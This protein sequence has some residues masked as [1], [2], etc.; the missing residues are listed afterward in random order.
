MNKFKTV[1]VV[2]FTIYSIGISAQCKV[3]NN[4]FQAGEE[5]KYDLYFKY[6]LIDKKAGTSSLTT[7]SEKYNNVDAYKMTFLVKST[8]FAKSLFSL[9]DTLISYTTKN[10]E[11][12]AF[13]KMAHEGKENTQEN[14]T[15]KYDA[16]GTTIQSKRVKNGNLM[17]DEA[18]TS[19][20][21][22]Y[23]FINVVYYARTI[24]FSKMKKGDVTTVNVVSGRNI[25]NMLIEYN[26]IENV[27]ANNDK[28]Y[29]CIKLILSVTNKDDKAF[30]NKKEAMKVY[31]TNDNNRIPI[32][33]DSK[34]KVG[35]TKA[36]LKSYKGNRHPL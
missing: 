13:I 32:R 25:V 18:I 30:A 29:S 35:S 27:E 4:A 8:G 5:L 2:F 19:Q 36:I 9:N 11:P 14:V 17:F 34:L 10:L 22:V 1:I 16:K 20:G 3:Q 31:L 6:G 7:T 33:L 23:D 12:L 24:D 21:C 26:G 15:Y 28:K